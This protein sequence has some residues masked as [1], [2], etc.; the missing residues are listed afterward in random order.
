MSANFKTGE[1]VIIRGV[2]TD[3]YNGKPSNIDY[4]CVVCQRYDEHYKVC[5]IGGAELFNNVYW[6]GLEDA[7]IIDKYAKDLMRFSDI[8]QYVNRISA[9]ECVVDPNYVHQL[10]NQSSGVT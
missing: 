10:N 5:V 7:K 4:V 9:D 3:K 1:L 8:M 6:V 2:P